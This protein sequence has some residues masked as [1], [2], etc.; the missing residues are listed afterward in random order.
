M[1]DITNKPSLQRTQRTQ[2]VCTILFLLWTVILGFINNNLIEL[3]LHKSTS[4]A[5]QD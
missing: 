3:Q 5:M 4:S 2:D 1:Q